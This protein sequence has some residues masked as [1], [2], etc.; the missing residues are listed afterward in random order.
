MN[1]NK[2]LTDNSTNARD[3]SKSDENQCITHSDCNEPG[4]IDEL[5]F[6]DEYFYISQR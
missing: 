6:P 4:D 5:I 1:Q 3:N 2:F